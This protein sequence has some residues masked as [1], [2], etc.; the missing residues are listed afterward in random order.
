MSARKTW[1]GVVV[2]ATALWAS[3][4]DDKAKT[5][6]EAAKAAPAAPG[7]TPTGATVSSGETGIAECDRFVARLKE[8]KMHVADQQI[9]GYKQA[10]KGAA[11]HRD[12]AADG[13]KVGLA[14]LANCGGATAAPTASAK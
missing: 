12:A 11:Q 10:A 5:G 3:G 8:C 4:C 2:L 14:G 9:E 13:C 1:L 7:D 6:T